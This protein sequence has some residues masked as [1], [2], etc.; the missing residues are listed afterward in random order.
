MPSLPEQESLKREIGVRSLALAILNMTVGTG[1][2]VIPA[3]IAENLG[4][5]AI[6][7][8]LICGGLIFLIALCFAEVGSKITVTG[9]T[10]AYIE[11]AFGPF[12]GFLANNI[13]WFGSCVLSDAAIA[14]GLADTLKYFLPLLG[15]PLFRTLFFIL[16]FGLLA[17]LNIRSVKHGVRFI[18]LVA[19]GKLIPLLLLVIVGSGYVSMENLRWTSSP[20][21]GS[22]GAASL[23]LIFAFTGMETPITNSGEIKNAKR[24]VPLGIFFGITSVLILYMAIQLVTQGVLGDTLVAHKDSP[25]AAVA[26]IIF[27]PA[28]ITL[29][30]AATAISMLGALG[31]EILSIPRILYAGARD[32]IMPKVLG[33]VHP[34]FFTPHIAVAVYSLLGLLFAVSGGF[35]QLAIISGA[36][37]LLIYLGVVLATIQ[38]RRA[39]AENDEKTF[40]VPGGLIIPLLAVAVI[41]WLLTSLTPPQ[42]ISFAV[43]IV[44]L[45]LIYFSMQMMKKKA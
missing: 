8:Y 20:T 12:A 42:L 17:L 44:L 19:F 10:Y 13:F 28:G 23:L 2:F 39:H 26:G 15:Q 41:I 7:A 16:L 5:A 43:F 27:G 21:I 3:I 29:M 22:L 40:R 4:A 24:T 34:R 36:A 9:G 14:N 25:L 32:G 30:I 31:G 37:T 45:C 35:Q 11:T 18:E 38:L 33:S 1:I 6:L